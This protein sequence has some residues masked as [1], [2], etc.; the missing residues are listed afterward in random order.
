MNY[1]NCDAILVEPRGTK[2]QP[3]NKLQGLHIL[4]PPERPDTITFHVFVFKQSRGL[5]LAPLLDV[6]IATTGDAQE[7]PDM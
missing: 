1:F 7:T 2:F 6:H 5:A 4:Q 3:P